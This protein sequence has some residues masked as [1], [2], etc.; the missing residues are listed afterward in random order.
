MKKSSFTAL[1]VGALAFGLA[2][3]GNQGNS[4]DAKVTHKLTY[5][6]NYPDEVEVEQPESAVVEVEELKAIEAPADP[7]LEG[8][9]FIAWYTTAATVTPFDFAAGID[10]D[11]TVYAKWHQKDTAYESWALVGEFE[12]HNWDATYDGLALA[13]ENGKSYTI[14]DITFNEGQEWKIIHDH[15]WNNGEV[16]FSNLAENSR[17]YAV[18]N[19]GNIKMKKSGVYNI[20]LDIQSGK[21][22]LDRTADGGLYTVAFQVWLLGS[23]NGWNTSSGV[24]QLT[25]PEGAV[26]TWTGDVTLAAADEFKIVPVSL[27]NDE[28]T[29]Q[30]WKG[31][32]VVTIA[33]NEEYFV[34]ATN[35]DPNFVVEVAGTYTFSVTINSPVLDDMTVSVVK[36]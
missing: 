15:T 10:A 5:D 21:I 6:L 31:P 35:D 13:T 18:D 32:K 22:T 3:C 36:K 12:G 7:T 1:L 33:G 34:A 29:K 23:F 2:A 9:D 28:S 16:G 8:Y 19:G 30:N 25:G 26:G 4:G 24:G 27:M 17:Q 14:K 20:T 11:T